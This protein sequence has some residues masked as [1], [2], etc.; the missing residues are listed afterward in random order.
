[1]S[2]SKIDDLKRDLNQLTAPPGQN[3]PRRQTT[4]AEMPS[5]QDAYRAPAGSTYCGGS[6]AR[7]PTRTSF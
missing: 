3:H 4:V 5:I 6:G 2:P 1:M 7:F